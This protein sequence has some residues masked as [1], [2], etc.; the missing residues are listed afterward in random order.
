MPANDKTP[1]LDSWLA[2]NPDSG[3]GV[4]AWV[5]TLPDDIRKQIA[6]S[7]VSAQRLVRWLRAIGY[8]DATLSKVDNWRRANRDRRNANDV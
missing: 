3:P 2:D 4:V 7:T 5:D 1:S 6:E 8:E